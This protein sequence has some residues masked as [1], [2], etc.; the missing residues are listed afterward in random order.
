M[1]LRLT[2]ALLEPFHLLI[3]GRRS[4]DQSSCSEIISDKNSFKWVFPPLLHHVNGFWV[5]EWMK[6]AAHPC[7]ILM[8]PDQNINGQCWFVTCPF[9][10]S[11]DNL[12]CCLKTDILTKR[13]LYFLRCSQV[14]QAM[15]PIG[16]Q[17]CWIAVEPLWKNLWHSHEHHV[18][19]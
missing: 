8:L 7:L 6:N 5:P 3:Y 14:C 9:F 15:V 16:F 13:A 10:M 19:S 17:T 4:T 11:Y 18:N 1:E 2:V 12:W